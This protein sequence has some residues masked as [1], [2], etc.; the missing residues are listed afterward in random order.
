MMLAVDFFSRPPVI[1]TAYVLLGCSVFLLGQAAWW[2]WKR[3]RG[4][5]KSG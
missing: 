1:L 5:S 2:G 4:Q 3:L